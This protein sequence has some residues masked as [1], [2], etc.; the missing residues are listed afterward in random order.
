[1]PGCGAPRRPYSRAHIEVSTSI[2]SRTRSSAVSPW[3]D[4]N[5]PPALRGQRR[6]R[7]TRPRS[8]PTGPDAPRPLTL[9]DRSDKARRN[10]GALT[11][12]FRAYL[13]DRPRNGVTVLS[14]PPGLRRYLPIEIC[15]QV[16]PTAHGHTPRSG[17][18]WPSLKGPHRPRWFPNPADELAPAL[19]PPK[20]TIGGR[21]ASSRVITQLSSTERR[22]IPTF[23]SVMAGRSGYTG[24]AQSVPSADSWRLSTLNVSVRGSAV[25][26]RTNDGHCLGPRSGCSARKS[27]NASASNVAP[28]GEH[29][30]GHHLVAHRRVGDRIHRGLGDVRDSASGSARWA[31][32]RGSRRRPAS[33]RRAGPAKYA[34]P[35]SSR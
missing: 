25:L 17:H 27:R 20:P 12:Q 8:A 3:I 13:P 10:S 24:S 32:C 7:G 31:R 21:A 1:M 19:T 22:S 11:V 2:M 6:A 4:H 28:S 5:H 33:S 35:S 16:M 14:A 34:K 26:T 29:Q 30:R 23:R 18:R 15:L 9:A